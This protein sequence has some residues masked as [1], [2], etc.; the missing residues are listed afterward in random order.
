MSRID[1][2]VL[3]VPRPRIIAPK[4]RD[5][6]FAVELTIK[7]FVV[8]KHV[9]KEVF[10]WKSVTYLVIRTRTTVCYT[11]YEIKLFKIV[12]KSYLE[13]PQGPRYYL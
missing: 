1:W 4:L 6:I 13:D 9:W 7:I 10:K 11:K 2:H 3:H 5:N 8:K 12:S